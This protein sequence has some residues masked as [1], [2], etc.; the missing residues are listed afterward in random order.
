MKTAYKFLRKGMKSN[1]DGSKWVV[2]KWRTVEAPKKECVGLN[3]SKYI[4]D[5]LSYVQGEILAKVEYGGKVIASD[6]KLTCE[7]MRVVKVWNWDKM[8]SVKMAV[9]SARLVL[10]IFEKERPDSKRPRAAIEAA[11]AWIDN[12]TKKNAYAAAAYAAYAA[13]AASAAASRRDALR[14]CADIVRG[15]YPMPPE[16]M[17]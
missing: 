1:H 7:K 9:Y 16:A 4:R 6:D 8:E 17:R 3:C 2:G 13:A 5:A 10:P 14:A 12:P 15:H 11:E